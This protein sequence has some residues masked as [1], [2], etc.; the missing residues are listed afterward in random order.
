M[1][2]SAR[3]FALFLFIVGF[4]LMLGVGYKASTDSN[5]AVRRGAVVFAPPVPAGGLLFVSLE[6][7][8]PQE[9][10]FSRTTLVIDDVITPVLAGRI[11]A[12]PDRALARVMLNTV[13]G[14]VQSAIAIANRLRAAKAHTHVSAG[15]RCFSA[16]AL[17]YQGGVTRS[18]DR[19]ALFLLHYAVQTA[20]DPER[21]HI[22]SIWGTVALI[23]A[24]IDLGLD[25]EIYDQMPGFGDWLLTASQARSLGLVQHIGPR[26]EAGA[27]QDT[28]SVRAWT[29]SGQS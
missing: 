3:F 13:G 2:L 8:L 11:L 9:G 16:C 10:A 27:V 29:G 17:V 1:N 6:S 7:A 25:A 4:V 5:L 18:A 20:D 15:A 28:A 24:M 22:G 21:A 14:D 23:E 19:E 26:D 12:L